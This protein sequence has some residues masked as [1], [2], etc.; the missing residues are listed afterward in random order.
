[1]G[2]E[3]P[4]RQEVI[5]NIDFL[6]GTVL[7]LG[8]SDGVS[9]LYFARNGYKVTNVDKNADAIADFLNNAKNESLNVEG[10]VTDLEN[11]AMEKDYDNVSSFF[12]L[13]F[14]RRRKCI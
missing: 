2:K 9:A 5:Y 8:G 13:H 10:V 14:F 7:D 3:P 4:P 6:P 1:M 12:T 11:Y